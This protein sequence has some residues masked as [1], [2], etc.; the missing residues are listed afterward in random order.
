MLTQ[1]DTLME[2]PVS[3]AKGAREIK[4]PVSFVTIPTS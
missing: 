2:N 4:K 1:T 3:D